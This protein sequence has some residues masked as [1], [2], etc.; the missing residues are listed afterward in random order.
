M[1]K[2]LRYLF[3]I[4]N[5][6]NDANE[7]WYFTDQR[8]CE[9]S[10]VISLLITVSSHRLYAT[11]CLNENL[12]VTLMDPLFVAISDFFS[13]T[14]LCPSPLLPSTFPAAC[15]FTC[16]FWPPPRRFFCHLSAVL[17]RP[18]TSTSIASFT[19]SQAVLKVREGFPHVLLGPTEATQPL[20]ANGMISGDKTYFYIHFLNMLWNFS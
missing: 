7:M 11:V 1:C 5:S 15:E 6:Y 12:A 16:V 18:I 4:S 13:L 3:L 19:N 10:Q 9:I 17:W 2:D 8:W 14:T 20:A